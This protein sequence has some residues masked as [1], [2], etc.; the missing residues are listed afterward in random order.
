M[1]LNDFTGLRNF[2]IDDMEKEPEI[3][4]IL[5]LDDFLKLPVNK[6][7]QETKD[8]QKVDINSNFKSSHTD[9]DIIFKS[10]DIVNEPNPT[11]S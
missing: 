7:Y 11:Q 1:D 5:T 4:K 8:K 9:K 2:K 10:K 3:Q 6:E